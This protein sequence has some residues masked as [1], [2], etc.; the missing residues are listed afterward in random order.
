VSLIVV[1]LTV[2]PPPS[3]RAAGA[4]TAGLLIPTLLAALVTG[5]IARRVHRPHGWPF[6]QLVLLALPVSLFFRLLLAVLAT[7]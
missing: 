4:F 5:L 7:R 6:W 2:G 3:A 1:L